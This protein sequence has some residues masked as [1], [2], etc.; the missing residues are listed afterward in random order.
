MISGRA[1]PV[2]KLNNRAEV[3][4]QGGIGGEEAQVSVDTRC[5]GMVVSST[6]MSVGTDC[7]CFLGAPLATISHEFSIR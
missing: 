1:Y 5:N 2:M 3:A 4:C 6:K 7:P